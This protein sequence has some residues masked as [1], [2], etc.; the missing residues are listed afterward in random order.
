MNA[1]FGKL[2]AQMSC[3]DSLDY[4]EDQNQSKKKR[5]VVCLVVIF[6]GD[7][8]HDEGSDV[9][10]NRL[11]SDIDDQN[12]QQSHELKGICLSENFYE[13]QALSLTFSC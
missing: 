11:Y 6:M 2:V 1:E 10:T 5:T 12:S 8:S 7:V 4:L 9:W 13:G 3:A